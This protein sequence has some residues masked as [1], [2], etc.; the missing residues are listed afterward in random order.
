MLCANCGHISHEYFKPEFTS[1]KPKKTK[2]SK[3]KQQRI[4]PSGDGTK[5]LLWSTLT[6]DCAKLTFGFQ[7]GSLTPVCI[8]L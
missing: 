8:M 1:D 5:D 2:F 7:S 6:P 3:K 4:T